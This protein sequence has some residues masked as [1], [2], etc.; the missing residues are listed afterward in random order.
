MEYRI[1]RWA[2]GSRAFVAI[3]EPEYLAVLEAHKGLRELLGVEEKFNV[4]LE[5][6]VELEEAI[7]HESLQ[8][9]VFSVFDAVLFQQSR[10]HVSR[11]IMNL[12]TSCRLYLDILPHHAAAIFGKGSTSLQKVKD[13]PSH[14]YDQSLAYR[15]MEGLRNHAQHH[16]LPVHGVSAE[17]RGRGMTMMRVFRTRSCRGSQR[18]S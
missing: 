9:L 8:H 17:P 3:T 18:K 10:N 12:L 14:E 13:A 11:R 5:N 1:M 16:E 7:F 2:I 15:V 4:L 6:Y